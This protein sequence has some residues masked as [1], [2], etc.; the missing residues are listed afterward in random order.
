LDILA[1]AVTSQDRGLKLNIPSTPSRVSDDDP[2]GEN[3]EYDPV[4]IELEL[5]AQPGE[6][7]QIGDDVIEAEEPDYA[8][9]SDLA[10]KVLERSHDLRAAVL[11]AHAEL[12]R[13]GIPE[14][15]EAVSFI[16]GRRFGLKTGSADY[17]RGYIKEDTIQ[18]VSFAAIARA[19]GRIE[20]HAR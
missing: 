4:Y 13:N 6:E 19:A 8:E 14:F 20:Q 3:L 11:L 7:R 9:I 17:L 12:S 16:V 10:Q 2:S 15:A 1:L 18:H 5:A